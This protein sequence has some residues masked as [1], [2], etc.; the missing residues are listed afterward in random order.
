MPWNGLH[1]HAMFGRSN[2][3]KEGVMVE[4]TIVRERC[5]RAVFLILFG[6]VP[7]DQLEVKS[8]DKDIRAM[9]MQDAAD[10]HAAYTQ[11][12]YVWTKGCSRAA[13]GVGRRHSCIVELGF[14]L[15]ALV[16]TRTIIFFCGFHECRARLREASLTRSRSKWP[17]S[18]L[19]GHSNNAH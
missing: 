9:L 3:I 12:M 2:E 14:H 4:G 7:T 16:R 18:K 19:K 10:G 8:A 5:A 6:S 1:G 13:E 11:G 17:N 15:L